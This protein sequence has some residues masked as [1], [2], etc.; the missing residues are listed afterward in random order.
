[1][2]A[3]PAL[4]AYPVQI[5]KDGDEYMARF[6]DFG[7]GSTYGKTEEEALRWSEDLLEEIIAGYMASERA[8]PRP[9]PARRRPVVFLPPLMAAKVA[10]Y[11]AMQEA[12]VS[13]PQLAARLKRSARRLDALFDLRRETPLDE[14]ETA[15]RAVGQRL[16]IRTR[17]AA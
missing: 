9:S 12:G 2:K 15:L 4:L 8:I 11:R 10:L 5:R 7:I 13:K 14:I 1:M 17:A 16:D 6:P 3:E